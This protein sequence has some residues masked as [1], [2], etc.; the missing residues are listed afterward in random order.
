MEKLFASKN[1]QK[2]KIISDIIPINFIKVKDLN[3]NNAP[4]IKCAN[5]DQFIPEIQSGGEYDFLIIHLTSYAFNTFNLNDK[6]I[7]YLKEILEAIENVIQ[8]SQTI[9]ILNSIH[10]DVAAFSQIEVVKK[11]MLA[12]QCNQLIFEFVEKHSERVIF[13]DV[14]A[15]ITR[16]GTDRHVN[17]RNYSVMRAP[18]SKELAEKIAKMYTLKL[19]SYFQP[20]IKIIFVDAD[21]TLW[22]GVVGEDGAEGVQIG[23]EYPG[24]IYYEFQQALLDLKQIGVLLCL[25]TKNNELDIHEVFQKRK[26]PLSINDFAKISANWERKS[27][28]ITEILTSLNL[29]ADSAIFI[30][31]NKFELEEVNNVHPAIESI[32]FETKHTSWYRELSEKPNIFRRTVTAEDLVRTDVYKKEEER[33]IFQKSTESIEDYLRGLRIS[34]TVIKNE[35]ASIRRIAQL[36]QKTNQFNLTTKRYTEVEVAEMMKSGNV[37]A[38]GATDKFGDMG[39]IGVAIV[40]NRDIDTFLLSCRAFGRGI[41]DAMLEIILKDATIFPIT[42]TYISSHKNQ[43]TSKFYNSN[44][45]EVLSETDDIVKYKI[46]GYSNI[47]KHHIMEVKWTGMN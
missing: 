2:I 7:L 27:S 25:V 23:H 18:Y 4:E 19:A 11:K 3:I 31:D 43:L 6:Y 34:L 33:K 41:E 10:F 46:E 9:F 12:M 38:F 13:V 45:F 17:P 47:R 22:G 21:N 15:E 1:K 40:I 26:M 42:S 44:G 28:S 36:T 35:P 30:D 8:T 32:L 20:K 37:Y 39:V 29:G 5:V 14:A 24:S 16:L